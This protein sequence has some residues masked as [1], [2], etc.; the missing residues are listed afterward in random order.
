MSLSPEEVRHAARLA[1]LGLDEGEVARFAHQLSQILDYFQVL[2]ELDTQ[3]VPPTSHTLPLQNV[4]R[5]D[6]GAPSRRHDEVLANAPL[7]E[8]GFFRVRAVLE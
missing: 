6:E 4:V 8:E 3:E 1:R 2:Q 7:R 5:D